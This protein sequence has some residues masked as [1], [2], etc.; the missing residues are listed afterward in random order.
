MFR[1]TPAARKLI[2][3]LT[4]PQAQEAWITRPDSGAISV[5]RLV[6]LGDYPDPVS[7][8]LASDLLRA[9]DVRFDASDSMPQVMESAFNNAVLE[10]LDSP[11]QLNVILTG[12]D[13]VRRAA[14]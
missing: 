13:Q 14:Y 1:N 6:P 5:N 8:G 2:A 4:T 12:L 11:R 10:Y 3:Y 7:R 9:T